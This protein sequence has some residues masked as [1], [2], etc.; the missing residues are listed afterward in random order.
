[1]QLGSSAVS[2]PEMQVRTYSL[3]A[4]IRPVRSLWQ[5][6]FSHDEYIIN[7][8][9][10][11]KEFIETKLVEIDNKWF[12]L[13]IFSVAKEK[14]LY[15]NYIKAI[16]GSGVNQVEMLDVF[17]LWKEYLNNSFYECYNIWS[18]KQ[19]LVTKKGTD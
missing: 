2:S 4:S 8:L 16:G 14:Q 9:T 6:P 7:N 12:T 19:C 11:H 17:V 13:Y 5:R 1:M 15:Y 10:N 3:P 18:V